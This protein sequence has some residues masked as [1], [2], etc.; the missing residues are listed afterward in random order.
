MKA[1]RS[2]RRDFLAS[3]GALLLSFSLERP[4]DAQAAPLPGS[5]ARSRRLDA[6]IRVGADGSVTVLSGKC[7]IGQG[8]ATA[9]AQIAADELDVDLERIDMVMADT[10]RTPNEGYTAG[11]L[12]I[13]Q[14]GTALRQAAAEVRQI[15]VDLAAQRL[16]AAAA[17][18]S[19][20]D[21]R[22][23]ATTG[24]S[25]TYWELID[26]VEIEQEATG[27]A[28]PKPAAERRYVGQ[29]VPRLD[30]PAKVF[31]EASFVHD[32][33][34]EG[35]LH[36][37]VVRPP[38]YGARLASVDEAP[39]R[40]L[41]GVVEVV[42]NGSFLAAIARREE[43][44]LAAATSLRDAARWEGE[45][46]LP[47]N[48]DLASWL[49]RQPAQDGVVDSV[50]PD[51]AEVPAAKSLEAEYSKPYLAHAALAPS[52]AVALERDGELVIWT[53]SQG[54]FPLRSSVA[55]VVGLPEER[56]RAIHMD[57]AGC[58]G[59]NG[60]D[61]AACDAAV[62]ARALPGRP[63][64]VLWS[65]EDELRWAPFGAA[66]SLRLRAGLD[67]EGRIVHWRHELWS[68]THSTRPGRR[69][70]FVAG[71]HLASPVPSPDA[72]NIP[73]PFG[74]ADRNAVP[75]YDFPSRRVV[76]H[77]LPD[78]PV[79]VSALRSL[80]AFAN[81]LAIESFMD[82]LA[83]AAGIDPIAF[84]LKHLKDERGRRVIELAAKAAGWTPASVTPRSA[85]SGSAKKG[86]GFAFSRYKN[87]GTY[88]ALVID[89]EVDAS[90]AVRVEKAVAAVD[91]GEVINPDGLRNQI[92]GGIV[93]AASWTLYEQVTFD[94]QKITSTDWRRYPIL[95]FPEAP[96]V[97]VVLVDQPDKDP[98]G[99]GEAAQGPTAAAISNAVF[100]ATGIRRRD[101]PLNAGA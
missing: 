26:G 36:A 45:T 27:R 55:Q 14:S 25:T 57:G 96:D 54:V 52:C 13:Q 50:G 2:T 72:V 89:V 93:Q 9:L 44:A 11:S 68:N 42:R 46:A 35:M 70:S 98:L 16:G 64:R 20:T 76:E 91:A 71:W 74:G 19:I 56:I 73:Q 94:R 88:L 47:P 41:E 87:R 53:H 10:G 22:I 85:E 92:E 77:F 63:V 7:E 5:L 34:L 62:L 18:L 38:S 12:S 78:M 21:G 66:M 51:P 32:L 90:G 60:A 81:I 33:R 40:A 15:L 86:R 37:R 17:D 1:T 61:D 99:V 100:A 82:D 39:A 43:Q 28:T 80:G 97:E 30:L 67:G 75:L 23:S 48:A 29:S 3:S 4:R 6:W 84:R 24:R 31:G 101:L 95:E 8:L 59:H 65:R 83:A 79:R 58:F 69:P 49:R